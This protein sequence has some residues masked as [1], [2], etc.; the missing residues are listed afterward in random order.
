MP[1]SKGRPKSKS[2]Q[3]AQAADPFAS[4][5]GAKEGNAPWFLPVMVGLMV[6]GL[7]YVVIFYLVEG[8]NFPLPIGSWN[9]VVGL[10]IV[11]AGFIMS[12]N[13]R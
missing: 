5:A 7:L 8:N 1:E 12:T 10:G 11:M 2:K 9:L 3:R 6:V 13:W 4:E